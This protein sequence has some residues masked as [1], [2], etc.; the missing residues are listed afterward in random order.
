MNIFETLNWDTETPERMIN[1]RIW[2]LQRRNGFKSQSSYFKKLHI[3]VTSHNKYEHQNL[4]SNTVE[5]GMDEEQFSV[6]LLKMHTN[7]D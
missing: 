5:M 2:I 6:V 1:F 4:S 3:F 7:L